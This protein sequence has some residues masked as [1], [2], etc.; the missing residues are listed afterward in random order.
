MTFIGAPPL[1]VGHT[2]VRDAAGLQQMVDAM[3]RAPIRGVD[4]ETN[5][6][7]YYAGDHVIGYSMG[8]LDT[9]GRPHAWYV[10]MHHRTMEQQCPAGPAAAAFAD[11]L[12]GA[13]GI[14]GHNLKFDL[15]MCRASGLKIPEWAP[16]HDTMVQAYLINEK[17]RFQLEKLVAELQCSPYGNALEMKDQVQDFLKR[18]AK[19]YKLPLRKSKKGPD[20]HYMGRFGHSEVPIG[21]EGEYA[22]RDIG[23]TLTL[24]RIQRPHAMGQGTYYVDRRQQLYHD[25]MLLVRALAEME[26]TGQRLDVDYLGKFAHWLDDYLEAQGRKLTRAFGRQ[27]R[28]N[29]D[30]EMREL[31]FGYLKLPVQGLTKKF[32]PSVD[33]AALTALQRFHPGV[34]LLAEWRQHF[35]VRSTYTDSLIQRVGHDGRLHTSFKQTGTV[36]GRLASADPNLQNIPSRH[37]TLSKAIR[38]AFPVD[39]GFVRVHADYSQIELRLL[40]HL[41]KCPT[42]LNAYQSP[43]YE[44]YLRQELTYYEYLWYRSHEPSIDVHGATARNVFG[45]LPEHPDWK[46]KRSAAKIVNFGVPYGASYM[47][48]VSDPNLQLDPAL[49]IQFFEDYGTRNPEIDH[50]K[51][52]LF[53]H[54]CAHPDGG[55]GP[56]FVN[57]A[58]R[59]RHGPELLW[60][61]KSRGKC[62]VASAER[63]LFASWIQGSAGELTRKSIVKLWLA[64][65]RGELPA[66]ATTTIHDDIGIDCEIRHK[67]FVAYEARRHMEDFKGEFG[68]VPVVADLE[69]TDTTWA[70]KEDYEPIEGLAA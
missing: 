52:W 28:W 57:W 23:H 18:R 26:W 8:F 53:E 30:T 41:T 64:W 56:A 14:V 43:A 27:F 16:I 58:G 21:L 38:K 32:Q 20:F 46:L 63:S 66:K 1:S 37:P 12:E 49:A 24:D 65:K 70:A 39:P 68:N 59:M 42:F 48:L 35:K 51:E 3:R 9:L 15:N 7:R 25:E 2:I 5:G 67:Q 4:T 44:A 47:L 33:K 60:T 55:L 17:R 54:M 6:L 11:A 40:A 22:C 62:P 45:A 34:A 69:V 13:E 50:A 29:N 10:P 31:L 19:R 61:R 36:T